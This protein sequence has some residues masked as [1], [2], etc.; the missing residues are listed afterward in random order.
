MNRFKRTAGDHMQNFAE[1]DS[2]IGECRKIARG[3]LGEAENGVVESGSVAGVEKIWAIGH[4]CVLSW[5]SAYDS[6]IDTAWLWRYTQTQQKVRPL[7]NTANFRLLEAGQHSVTSWIA[8][9]IINSLRPRLSSTSGSS[10]FIP[11]VLRG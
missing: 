1:V 4:W 5:N 2:M 8:G 11:R 6:H 10:N 3:V 9:L 7:D